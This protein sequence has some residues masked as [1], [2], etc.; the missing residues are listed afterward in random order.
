MKTKTA[1]KTHKEGNSPATG[2]ALKA[3]TNHCSLT[4]GLS[5]E[6]LL[7]PGQ[8]LPVAAELEE[9]RDTAAPVCPGTAASG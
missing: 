5:R 6:L 2:A 7:I 9:G 3:T 4:K 1:G 8:S